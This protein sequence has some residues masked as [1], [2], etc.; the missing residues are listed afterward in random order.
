MITTAATSDWQLIKTKENEYD[1][2]HQDSQRSTVLYQAVF[3][4]GPDEP[5]RLQAV[6]FGEVKV[7]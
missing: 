4:A 5:P 7:G 3:T 2:H 1:G 6:F